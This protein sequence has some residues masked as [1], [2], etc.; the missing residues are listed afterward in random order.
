M[1][2]LMNL[3]QAATRWQK[4]SRWRENLTAGTVVRLRRK[5]SCRIGQRQPVTNVTYVFLRMA[6]P[7][8]VRVPMW[9]RGG[10]WVKLY[11]PRTDNISVQLLGYVY[12]ENEEVLDGMLM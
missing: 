7:H 3:E 12:P 1:M 8:E 5:G 2:G 11:N 6:K 4:L 10:S 9:L